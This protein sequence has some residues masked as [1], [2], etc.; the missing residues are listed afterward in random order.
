MSGR[1]LYAK[2]ALTLCLALVLLAGCAPA[3]AQAAPEAER[4]FFAMDTVMT[5]AAYG[6][7]AAEAGRRWSGRRIG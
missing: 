2:S 7:R 3:P 4:T 6:D 5:F 1:T